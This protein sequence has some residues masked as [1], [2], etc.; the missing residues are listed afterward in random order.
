MKIK[1]LMEGQV[2]GTG[3]NYIVLQKDNKRYLVEIYLDTIKELKN[4][5]TPY[6]S[7]ID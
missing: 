5:S 7:Q 4:S 6:G 2:V 1:D 3:S